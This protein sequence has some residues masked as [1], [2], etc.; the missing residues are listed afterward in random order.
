MD[1]KRVR[2]S[3]DAIVGQI[4]QYV[5]SMA[6]Y[7]EIDRPLGEY[8]AGLQ[9]ARVG[10]VH[11][12]RQ[13][14]VARAVRQVL[15]QAFGP[16]AAEVSVD[17]SDVRAINIVDHH[18]LLNHPLLLGTNI[19]ANADRLVGGG[20]RRPIVTFSCSNVPP[21]NHYMRNGFQFRGE[22]IP[23]FKAKEHRDA[24]YYTSVRSFDF[25][26]RLRALK[27]WERFKSDDQAFLI[28]Y[29]GL[30]NG[31]DY[32]H[33]NRHRDQLAVALRRTWPM[34][35][36]Q[37]LRR[38][39]PEL[40][41]ANS[42]DVARECLVELLAGENFLSAALFD[43]EFRQHVLDAFRGI[44]VAW[45]EAAGKGT[46]FFWRKYPGRPELLRLFVDGSDLVPADPR[47]KDL[48]VP[49][50]PAAIRDHLER[51]EI[52]PSVAL[53]MS[54]LLYAG[55]K[56]LVGPGS[57]VY[58]TQLKEGWTALLER[59]GYASEASLVAQVDTAG[60]I[61]GTPMFFGRSGDAVRTLYAADVFSMGGMSESYMKTALS[62][63]LKDLLSVGSSGVY[64]LFSNSYIPK[65]KQLTER[66]GFDEAAT[67]I[68]GWV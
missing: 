31:L 24:M 46:H 64:D 35:F 61:A 10:P 22:A 26:E 60:L 55:V 63:P 58:T 2:G 51:E 42:E 8:A 47:F 30:L 68:H 18:Q 66:I 56:P 57:L 43:A 37:E 14:A 59:H 44:V 62:A 13:E 6:P 28:E 52:I 65:E 21:S 33:T 32:S 54:V 20:G 40:L 9:P 50:E 25:V 49:L 3:L 23:Y 15:R 39:V 67:I 17:A 45:D 27:R 29:Q 53:C 19:I 38:D 34:L 7:F 48:K 4:R 36:S 11:A 41:Y 12:D 5:P 16:A 1:E